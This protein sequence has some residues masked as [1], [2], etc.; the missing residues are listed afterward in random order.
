MVLSISF[1]VSSIRNPGTQ[2]MQWM[3][4]TADF[5]ST[6]KENVIG[7][8]YILA[9]IRIET[10]E[11]SSFH[12]DA[13]RSI[14]IWTRNPYSCAVALSFSFF[15]APDARWFQELQKFLPGCFESIVHLYEVLY[16]AVA[17]WQ[18][19]LHL[20]FF[21]P[22]FTP[23]SVYLFSFGVCAWSGKRKW[24]IW[25]RKELALS[26][27]GIQHSIL[28]FVVFESSYPVI[29]DGLFST[30]LATLQPFFSEQDIHY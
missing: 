29:L 13:D 14:S 26:A 2:W 10:P 11:L 6:S 27:A 7:D 25:E 9:D 16:L 8:C 15:G 24:K 22:R 23:F 5:T 12:Y 4:K 20:G 17:V 30:C 28:Q 1:L 21:L 18:V 3:E 19:D